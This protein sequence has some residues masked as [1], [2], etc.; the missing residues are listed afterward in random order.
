M[1]ENS[2]KQSYLNVGDKLGESVGLN[3]GDRVGDVGCSEV[4]RQKKTN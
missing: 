4:R 2:L 3:V 1:H